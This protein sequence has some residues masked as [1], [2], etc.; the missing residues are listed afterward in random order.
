M[1]QRKRPGCWPE[2]ACLRD[3]RS[4]ARRYFCGGCANG[5][6]S[7]G[8]HAARRGITMETEILGVAKTNRRRRNVRGVFEKIPGSGEWWI[9]YVDAEGR[10]RREKAG[11]KGA[12]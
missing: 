8:V 10:Y 4:G 3:V 9:R 2:R 1:K 5:A 11:T 12:A 7:A 6:S